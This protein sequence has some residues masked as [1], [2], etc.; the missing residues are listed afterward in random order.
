MVLVAAWHTIVPVKPFC[1]WRERYHPEN[2]RPSILVLSGGA[3]NRLHLAEYGYWFTAESGIVSIA[4]VIHG[5]L[6]DLIKHRHEA[7]SILCKFIL[8]E[9]IPAFPVVIVEKDI[10]AAVKAFLQCHGI[11]G[12]RPNSVLLGWSQ[13][14]E[15][16]EMFY[17]TL[18]TVQEM[19]CS[20]I[21]AACEEEQEKVQVPEGFINVW[22]TAAKNGELILLLA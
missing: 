8:K 13:D 7:E 15:K 2:W 6:V 19:K 18:K 20:L 17:E 3:Y 4:Q 1:A 22:W 10:H 14:P 12:M 5:E 16:T 21:I 9:D 11:G